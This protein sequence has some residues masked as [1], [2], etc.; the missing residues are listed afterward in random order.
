MKNSALFRLVSRLLI[1]SMLWLPFSA[2]AAMVGTSQLV[3]PTQV[4]L[5]R[6]KLDS[7]VA[8]AD[9]TKQLEA[10]GIRPSVAKQRVAGLTDEEVQQVSGHLNGLPAGGTSGW[11]IAA[12]VIVIALIV[13]ALY[14]Y[15]T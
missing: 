3:A 4:Q 13:W 2:S 9:V 5:D 6:Q 1:V 11:A 8:R 15:N 14:T 10:L 12:G 7:F